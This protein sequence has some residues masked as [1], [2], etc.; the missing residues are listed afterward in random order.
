[1]SQF[2]PPTSREGPTQPMPVVSPPAQQVPDIPVT[3]P[4]PIYVQPQFYQ[5]QP[6]QLPRK[7]PQSPQNRYAALTAIVLV[8]IMVAVIATAVHYNA[9]NPLTPDAAATQEA[10]DLATA[11]AYNT[12][13]AQYTPIPTDVPTNAPT[14]Q[15]TNA[16]TTSTS[17]GWNTI[18][19]FTGS[20][21]QNTA[22]FSAPADWQIAWSCNGYGNLNTEGDLA[23]IIYDS[24]NNTVDSLSEKCAVAGSSGVSAE[25][26]G[27]NVY[28]AI[29]IAGDSWSVQVQVPG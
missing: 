24:Q 7:P 1:M 21:T 29:N 22:I 17:P 2:Q 3:P 11:N 26:Q 20:G 13:D 8:L 25:H 9:Q 4:Q 19:S 23:I 10:Q 15:P 5:Q 16:P 14:Q 6:P 28:L 27:G 18:Q 12:Q